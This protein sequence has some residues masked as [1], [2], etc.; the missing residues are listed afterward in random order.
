VEGYLR[1]MCLVL[2]E[3][4]RVLRPGGAAVFV[5]G[6]ASLPSVTVDVDVILGEMG[7]RLGLTLE[8]IWVGNVRWA[9]VHGIEKERPARESAVILR[10]MA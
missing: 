7:E 5:V 2:K 8:D 6:N 1:D 3:T 10:K 4:K 9:G